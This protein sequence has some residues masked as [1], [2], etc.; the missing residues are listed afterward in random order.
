MEQEYELVRKR[1]ETL[2]NEAHLPFLE[3]LLYKKYFVDIKTQER[4]RCLEVV[5]D[6]LMKHRLS[7]LRILKLIQEREEI[8]GEIRASTEQFSSGSL[9]TLEVQTRVLQLLSQHQSVTLNIVEQVEEWR[10]SLTRPFP[11]MWH[12]ENYLVKIRTDCELIDGSALRKVLPL[13]LS[14][15]PLSS[16]IT[17]LNLFAPTSGKRA[18]D[19]KDKT[20]KLRAAEAIIAEETTKQK[21]LMRELK[22][23]ADASRFVPLL[24]LPELVPE[25]ETGVKITKPEWDQQ[26]QQALSS[27]SAE[28]PKNVERDSSTP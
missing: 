11:F 23:I 10:N 14:Q 21:D 28:N 17:S 15:F 25:C 19:S 26:L 2:A 16:N 13:R 5:C 6:A 18:T 3:V 24:K 8:L 27:E 7:T 1:F 22:S 4:L 20:T 9:S 12:G